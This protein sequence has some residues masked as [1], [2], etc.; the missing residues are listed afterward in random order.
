M[1]T[2]IE[3]HVRITLDTGKEVTAGTLHATGNTLLFHYLPSYIADAD[4]FDLFPSMPRSLAS[5]HFSGLGPFSDSAPDRWGRKVFARSL[6]RTR[7]F[8]PEYLFGVNDLTRQ[9]AVRFVVNGDYVAG[10]EGVPVVANLPD[11]MNTA[12]AVEK[13]QEISDIALRRLYR[14]TG[15]LGGARPKAS[16]VDGDSLWLAKFPKPDGDNW[17]V[18]GWESVTLDIAQLAGIQVP[19]HRTIKI[20]DSE[21]RSRTVLL[22]QRFDRTPSADI[23]HAKRIPY[24][25]AMT[26]LEASDGEGGDWIDLAED[27]RL[28][29]A[30]TT[31][32]WRRAMFGAA[33]G[34]L[35]DHLRNHGFLRIQSSWHLAPAFDM[36]PEP[37]DEKMPD[38]HQLSFCGDNEV[39]T[40]T[41]LTDDA[42]AVF[43][44]SNTYANQW[45]STLRSSLSQALNRSKMQ[46]IDSS[47]I[48]L[49]STRF[50]HAIE[51]LS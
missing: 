15:S 14:A 46:H 18:I 20:Q 7:V 28:R 1:S 11:L 10:N 47:S 48:E 29:G 25:S 31:E 9:G 35:D 32:L 12:D 45:R 44:V 24:M 16:V 23:Q 27:A 13:N 43:G 26:A 6:K 37:Y 30:D 41:L 39:T 21:G 50:S 49:M 4:S 36:N 8:E 19:Q 5:F 38:S 17:D 2:T 51:L 33:I 42:L 40:N 3:A 22:V 34:N